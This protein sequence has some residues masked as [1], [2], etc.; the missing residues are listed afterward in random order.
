[1]F[2]QPS[3]LLDY[4]QRDEFKLDESKVWQ[5]FTVNSTVPVEIVGFFL[6]PGKILV[7]VGS[8]IDGL[9]EVPCAA[10]AKNSW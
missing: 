8:S 1:M 4:I 2:L 10:I 6:V 5:N 3:I 9:S 7:A